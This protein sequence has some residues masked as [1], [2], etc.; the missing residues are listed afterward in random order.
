MQAASLVAYW[1]LAGT[2]SPEPDSKG[3]G[4]L[5]IAGTMTQGGDDPTVDGPPSAGYDVSIS[6]IE[7]HGGG[8]VIA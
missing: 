7:P 8:G 4:D 2:A 6:L 1:P 3:W 5:T